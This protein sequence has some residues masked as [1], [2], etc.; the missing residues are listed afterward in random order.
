MA[1]AI[2]ATVIGVFFVVGLVVG[3]VVILALPL[4]RANL[5]G[6]ERGRGGPWDAAGA[7]GLGA[8]DDQ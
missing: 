4:I 7:A 6:T 1:F 3:V 2:V 8:A 5:S